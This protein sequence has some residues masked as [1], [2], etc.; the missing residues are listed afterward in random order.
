MLD[1]LIMSLDNTILLWVNI[2]LLITI[3]ISYLSD[4]LQFIIGDNLRQYLTQNRNF[5][6]GIY[7]IFLTI[8]VYRDYV[9]TSI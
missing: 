4:Q 3:S 9:T 8:K 1:N 5:I 7:Y 2:L 6:L